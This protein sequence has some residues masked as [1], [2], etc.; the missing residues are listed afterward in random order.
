MLP[1]D[2]YISSKIIEGEHQK[3]DFKYHIADAS[4]I[5]RTFVAFANSVGGEL[6]IG[7]KDNGKVVGVSSE[8]EI[9]MLSLASER[10]CKPHV[11]FSVQDYVIDDKTVLC[12]SIPKG[13][14]RPYYALEDGKWGVFIRHE[15]QNKFANAIL[16]KVLRKINKKENTVIRY[17]E[18]EQLLLSF[19]DENKKA[20][21][22]DIQKALKIRRKLLEKVLVQLISVN[23]VVMN[24]D[25]TDFYY[26][27]SE[28]AYQ[29]LLY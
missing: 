1:E 8:E 3:L 17:K 2:Q 25:G 23:V 20:G 13:Y 15:D 19:L 28:F 24:C 21:I 11:E 9:Y 10:Y 5:A 16:V 29:P 7:V 27:L 22:N 4:K 18:E 14:D 6:L 26:T 12:A